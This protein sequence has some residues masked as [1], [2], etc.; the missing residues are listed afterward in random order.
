M[1]ICCNVYCKRRIIVPLCMD[2]IDLQII[3]WDPLG[4]SFSENFRDKLLCF[5]V[6]AFRVRVRQT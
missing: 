4:I 1:A 5:G 3:E 6:V 2:T